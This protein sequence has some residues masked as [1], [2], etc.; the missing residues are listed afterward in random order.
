MNLSG[1]GHSKSFGAFLTFDNL[2]SRKRL[3]AFRNRSKFRP[4]EGG[5]YSVYRGILAL[6]VLGHSDVMRCIPIFSRIMYFEHDCSSKTV[7]GSFDA[8]DSNRP[9]T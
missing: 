8:R 9:V 2:A 7:W 4:G 3:A 1:K 5:G 6:S